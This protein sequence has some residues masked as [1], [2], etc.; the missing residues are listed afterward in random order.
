MNKYVAF[1]AVAG[2]FVVAVVV[3]GYFYNGDEIVGDA[4]EKVDEL[5]D[6]SKVVLESGGEV[7]RVEIGGPDIPVV[8]D[9]EGL[10]VGGMT[11]D[12]QQAAFI[13]NAADFVG[14]SAHVVAS[15][16]ED[17]LRGLD[18]GELERDLLLAQ[19]GADV[20][21]GIGQV[22]IS[23]AEYV[24]E[25]VE[26]EYREIYGVLGDVDRDD[27]VVRLDNDAWSALYAGVYLRMLVDQHDVGSDVAAIL[28]KGELLADVDD[29]K[30]ADFY[31]NGAG[32][33][34]ERFE[35]V[36]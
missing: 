25:V 30:L 27:M 6:Q 13:G 23:T 32:R 36:Y 35:K 19:S 29:A 34:F 21:M 4:K 7:E 1:F 8:F 11:V 17:E 9:A 18:E 33:F 5:V 26:N 24:H 20:S 16:I 10:S 28:Y 22:R 2:V 15:V 12:E 3:F 14:V 31:E